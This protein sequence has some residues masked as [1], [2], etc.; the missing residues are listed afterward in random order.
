MFRHTVCE[1]DLS[2]IRHNVGVMRNCLA[3]GVDFL[4]VV[5]ADGYGHGAVQVARAAISAGAKMLAVAIPEE[6]V[7]LRQA[8]IE[9]PILVLGGIEEDAAAAVA[10][11]DLTQ[12]V[13]DE[14]RVRALSAAGEAAGRKVK[15]H[16]KLD[17]ACAQGKRCSGL[18]G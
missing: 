9:T 18:S 13:F 17:T 12:S 4:A 16:L 10:Q 7:Q 6:G 11:Y 8:G 14:A 5:K 2:A 15:V 3:E 1:I